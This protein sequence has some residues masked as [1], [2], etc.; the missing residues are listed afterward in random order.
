M[1][2]NFPID[3]PGPLEINRKIGTMGGS[4]SHRGIKRAS[5]CSASVCFLGVFCALEKVGLPPEKKKNGRKTCAGPPNSSVN[6]TAESNLMIKVK[7]NSR[8]VQRQNWLAVSKHWCN[9]ETDDMTPPN[10]KI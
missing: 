5:F 10:M 7:G 3:R 8:S 6:R 2:A 1:I 4:D 9:V